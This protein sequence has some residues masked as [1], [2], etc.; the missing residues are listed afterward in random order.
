MIIEP[1]IEECVNAFQL[2]VRAN[3]FDLILIDSLGA[4]I[5]AVDFDGKDGSGGDA[6]TQ[7]VGGSSRVITSWVNKANAE[8]TRIEKMEN[9]GSEVIKPAIIYINQVRDVIG[10]RFPTQ[11]MPGGNALKHMMGTIT[12]VQAS[13]AT[14]DRMI[15]TVDGTKMQVGQRVMCTV[16][17]NK[18]APPRR[19]GGY[20]FCYEEC[21]EYGFGV[22]S[23]DAL[24]SLA[25]ERGVIE[26]KGR[27]ELVPVI[28]GRGQAQR[29]ER[30]LREA[31]ERPR[32]V[33]RGVRRGHGRHG[34]RGGGACDMTGRL[35]GRRG[36]ESS[37]RWS[38]ARWWWRPA[39]RAYSRGT[40]SRG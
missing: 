16:E 31:Q 6:N 8:L 34:E 38:A 37:H 14:A 32:A 40:S 15:G 29:Q 22:D 25:V 10:S 5:R 21:D 26:A 30:V 27:M 13:G 36:S 4:V 18:Y 20:L 3:C 9:V 24:Y 39:P 17:K 33:R 1:T 35:S 12:R 7:Q 11:G 23:S 2:A 19:Q 28:D